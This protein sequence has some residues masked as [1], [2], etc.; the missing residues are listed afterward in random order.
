MGHVAIKVRVN[1][2]NELGIIYKRLVP[3]F[4]WTDRGF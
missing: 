4:A 3:T 1:L 2:N